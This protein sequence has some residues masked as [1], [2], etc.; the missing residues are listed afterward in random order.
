MIGSI[1]SSMAK[2]SKQK[3]PEIMTKYSPIA[4][5]VAALVTA[6]ATPGLAQPV[7]H[8]VVHHRAV[9]NP[10]LYDRVDQPAVYDPFARPYV[11]GPGSPN[12]GIANE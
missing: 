7:H 11:G 10:A 6:G 9:L 12:F 3:G 4:L 5:A 1:N 2:S 8:R